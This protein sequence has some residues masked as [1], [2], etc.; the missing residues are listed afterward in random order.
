[1]VE[2]VVSPQPI[3]TTWRKSPNAAMVQQ[4]MWPGRGSAHGEPPQEQDP[5]Q[6]CSQWRGACGGVG[7][8]REL[9][10]VETVLG[11]RAP[12]GGPSGITCTLEGF[13]KNGSLWKV[14]K[15]V[16]GLKDLPYEAFSAWRT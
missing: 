1:M 12:E 2:E 11:Q 4:W 14:T 10:P 15:M 3:G 6:S 7:G 9:L 8:L 13:L 5:G 16:V